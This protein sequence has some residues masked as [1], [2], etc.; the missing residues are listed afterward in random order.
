MKSTRTAPVHVES[1]DE[2]MILASSVPAKNRY[3]FAIWYLRAD[4]K[5]P[6]QLALWQPRLRSYA[7]KFDPSTGKIVGKQEDFTKMGTSG[8]VALRSF[9]TYYVQWLAM[10][11]K[12][13]EAI[14]RGIE[15]SMKKKFP[16]G[17]GEGARINPVVELIQYQQLSPSVLALEYVDADD[18]KGKTAPGVRIVLAGSM[19]HGTFA[20]SRVTF[21]KHGNDWH[22]N[23]DRKPKAFHGRF[24]TK[25][26][27]IEMPNG[28]ITEMGPK[29]VEKTRGILA[30][31]GREVK[32]HRGMWKKH[33]GRA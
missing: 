12:K 6:Y 20:V 25:R 26:G 1:F 4:E 24:D 30:W 27:R 13:Y 3:G 8:R 2:K 28:H 16:F 22:W 32:E 14:S 19:S 33:V 21:H 31:F 15:R 17:S 11:V 9:A 29:L 7:L 23:A 5:D 18:A 10:T